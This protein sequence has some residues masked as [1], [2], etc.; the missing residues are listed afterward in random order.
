MNIIVIGNGG[1]EHAIAWKISQSPKVEKVVCV[2][3]NGGTAFEEKCIN[4][5]I[6]K[7][8]S[9]E[10]PYIEIAKKENCT[11]AVIGPE[12][13]LAEGLADEFWKAGIPCVGPKKDAAQLE[14]SK[15]LAKEF[16][17]KYNVACAKSE[18]FT[19]QQKASDYVR[20]HGAPIVIKADGL[21]AGKGV[22]H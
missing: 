18:T 5:Q 14:A 13:P 10:N 6:D 3:G 17:K 8:D 1:R 20:K 22:R 4:I 16:M 21:A 12:D 2:P 19:D 15:D 7:S 9:S 11:L